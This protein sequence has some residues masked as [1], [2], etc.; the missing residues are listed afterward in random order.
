MTLFNGIDTGNEL[1]VAGMPGPWELLLILFVLLLLFGGKKLPE[2]ARGLG[3]AIN[4]FK[5]GAD[6]I[7]K[8]IEDPERKNSAGSDEDSSGNK[9]QK[10]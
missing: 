7:K 1:L 2:I 6:D 8:E 9:S 4:E 3:Q 10:P 5:R